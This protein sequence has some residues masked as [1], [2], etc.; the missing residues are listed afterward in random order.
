MD[1]RIDP[2]QAA[3]NAQPQQ[4]PPQPQR[5]PQNMNQP[6][7]VNRQTVQNLNQQRVQPN[8]NQQNINRQPVQNFNQQQVQQ[9]PNRQ[10]VQNINQQQRMPQNFNQQQNFAPQP[11][12]AQP[13]MNQPQQNFNQRPVQNY[14]QQPQMAQ[15]QQNFNQQQGYVQQPQMAQQNFNQPPVQNFN[16]PVQPV[17]F[18]QQPVQPGFDQP[19]QPVY[20]QPVIMSALKLKTNRSL[21]KFILL[22]AITF[23]IYGIV[24]MAGVS[25]DIN[26]IASRYDG[27]KTMHYCI[28]SLLFTVITL[29]IVPIVWTHRLCNRI[30]SEL[31]RRN[32]PYEFS[33]KTFWL[34]G[35]LG[36][37]I[38][39]GPFI[40]MHKMLESMNKLSADFNLKGC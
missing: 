31:Q 22:S 19:M 25:T 33:A 20:V 9:N 34:W 14:N 17:Q 39:V 6:L 38:I 10:P 16:Q 27:K 15:P 8:M 26:T 11:Q 30:G 35:V 32:I 40:F 21:L 1:N 36:S 12:K 29:G 2:R 13:N 28:V 3:R 7:N 23:G 4:R 18:G 37:F 5:A 24:V